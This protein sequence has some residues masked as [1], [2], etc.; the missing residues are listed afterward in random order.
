MPQAPTAKGRATQ[1]RIIEGA[2]EVLRE[3][4]LA[5]TALDD[6]RSRTGTSKSRLF[7]YFPGGKDELLLA[8]A[9][10]QTDRVLDDQQPHPGAGG[11][12]RWW[13]AMNSR[14]TNARWDPCSCRSQRRR[15]FRSTACRRT[16]TGSSRSS[17]TR[18]EAASPAVRRWTAGGCRGASRAGASR[19]CAPRGRTAAPCRHPARSGSAVWRPPADCPWLTDGVGSHP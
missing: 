18:L 4:G 15:G 2:A 3:R 8:V 14:V 7:H 16:R 6:I 11:G 1:A 19:R 12:T 17:M 5:S 9:Q 10:F 13:S